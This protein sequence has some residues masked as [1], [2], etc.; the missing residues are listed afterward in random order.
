MM[1]RW[2]PVVIIVLVGVGQRLLLFLQHRG[3]LD[4]LLEANPA[5]YTGQ[6]LPPRMLT[7]HLAV[8]LLYLQQ[9]PPIPNLLMGLALKWFSWPAGVTYAL[10]ALQGLLSIATALLLRR[11]LLLLYP[12]RSVLTALIAIVF[13]LNTDLV[14]LEYNSFGQTFYEHVAMFLVMVCVDLLLRLRRFGSPRYAAGAGVAVAALALSRASWS[15]FAIPAAALVACLSPGARLRHAVIFLIPVVLLQGGWCIKNGIIFGR[16]SLTTSSWSGY[17]LANGLRAAGFGEEFRQF[18][19]A[20]SEG[21]GRRRCFLTTVGQGPPVPSPDA[22]EQD[23]RINE[24]LGVQNG[25][26]NSVVMQQLF[27]ECE[28]SFFAFAL[29]EP[30]IILRKA[31]RAYELFWQPPANY[32][33]YFIALFATDNPIDD[34]FNPISLAQLMVSGKLPPKQYVMSGQYPRRSFAE[35]S[36]HTLRWLEPVILIANVIAVHLLAPAALIL[37]TVRRL[38][39]G[40]GA[41]PEIDAFRVAALAVLVAVY[42]YQAL[43]VNVGDYGENM[44]FR[45]G[46]EPVIWLIT[47]ASA[48]SLMSWSRGLTTAGGSGSGSAVSESAR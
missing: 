45:I 33:R 9:T 13:L 11:V 16:L 47:V 26:L 1:I 5:W 14:V 43:V 29:H 7:D 6:Q 36:L 41:I 28:R 25:R 38:V 18:V 19:D 34:S 40:G 27:L 23:R 42:A 12:A 21:D 10:V 8:S 3:A 44:R 32:G 31:W 46:V 37:W 35:T 2:L 48:S 24:R 30:G 15:F 22:V 39:R 20:G 17:N 4:A